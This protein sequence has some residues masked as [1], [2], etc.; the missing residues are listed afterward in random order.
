MIFRKTLFISLVGHITV[1]SIFNLSF[2]TRIFKADYSSVSFL[3]SLL[4]KYDL[5]IGSYPIPTFIRS[6]FKNEVGVLAFPKGKQ[7]TPT[8]SKQYIK[9]P[10][11]ISLNKEKE[12]IV[13]MPRMM[14][15]LPIR[16]QPTLIFHPYL[17]YDF[18]LYF[19]DRQIV[20]I[21][22]SFNIVSTGKTSTIL[23]KRKVSSGNL[24]ADLLSMRYI[25]HYLFVQQAKFTPNSW[26]V[27]KIDLSAQ[28]D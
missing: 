13:H 15:K 23:I 9:P 17:P 16:K 18:L 26:Q 7:K 12:A 5:N 24:E 20:H 8:V 19:K 1:F 28:N 14:P 6:G 4:N 22:L 27:V 3:G 10:A 2:G 25:N 21:E 11:F